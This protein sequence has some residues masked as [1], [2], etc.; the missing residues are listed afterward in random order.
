M[1]D[2]IQS[3]QPILSV[4]SVKN[5]EKSAETAKSQSISESSQKNVDEYVPSVEKESIG[6]YSVS[7]DESGNL[8]VAFDA[9]SESEETTV[10]TDAVDRE[11]E[12]L[13]KE[14]TALERRLKTAD[15]SE[16]A[17]LERQL[18]QIES[19]LAMKDNDAY[20]MANAVIS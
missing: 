11:I 12:T 19:E 20:R 8:K 16:A 14:Q 3:N 7:S 13:E 5:V 9:A 15:E 10:N 6:L 4:G 2:S 1:I 17:E 18:E